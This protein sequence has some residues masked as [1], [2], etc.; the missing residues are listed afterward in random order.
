[1]GISDIKFQSVF[2]YDDFVVS[3]VVVVD[4]VPTGNSLILFE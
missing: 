3:R 1:M 4:I 2:W